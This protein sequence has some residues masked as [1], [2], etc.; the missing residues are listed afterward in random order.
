[1]SD[2]IDNVI[3]RIPV[4]RSCVSV[5]CPNP[6]KVI[7]TVLVGQLVVEQ[8]VESLAVF[9]TFSAPPEPCTLSFVERSPKNRNVSLLELCQLCGDNVNVRE[10]LFVLPSALLKSF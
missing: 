6:D 7:E 1:M 5:T 4:G 3:T 8:A 9:R 10:E 2:N